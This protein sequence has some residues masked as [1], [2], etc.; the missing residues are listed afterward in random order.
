[1]HRISCLN[2]GKNCFQ[3]N[4]TL[5]SMA[6]LPL[7]QTYVNRLINAAR[8]FI[9]AA[10]LI[11]PAAT[12]F[13]DLRAYPRIITPGTPPDNEKVFFDFTYYD[14]PK[15]KL[16]IF[17]LSGRKVREISTL[18]PQATATGWRLTWDGTDENGSY[19]LPGVYIYQWEEGTSVIN[20]TIVVSR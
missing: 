3:M 20:G 9:L 13:A 7:I 17:D 15:P 16:M 12:L 1:M 2:N 8:P 11:C 4:R 6:R 18:N 5:R 10:F 14:E 19:V